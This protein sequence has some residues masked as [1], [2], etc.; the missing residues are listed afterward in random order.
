MH[1]ALLYGGRSSEHDVSIDSARNI[2]AVL[3]R[4]GYDVL[5]IGITLEGNFYLQPRRPIQRTI[6]QTDEVSVLPG[7]G[8]GCQGTLLPIDAAFPVTHGTGGEDGNLQGLCYLANI[9]LCGCDT[10]SSALGMH[11]AITQAL[12]AQAGIPVVPTVTLGKTDLDWLREAE[13]VPRPSFLGDRF[14]CSTCT[15]R[16]DIAFPVLAEQ[17]GPALLAKPEASGS[18]VGVTALPHAD[19]LSLHGAIE[20]AARYGERV[21]VQPLLDPVEEI[22]CA[23]L[24]TGDGQVVVSEPGL[25]IDPAHRDAGFLT[26]EH[27]Y[28]KTDTAHMEVPAPLDPSVRKQIQRYA[29]TAF[30][31]IKGNGYARIDFFRHD[32]T[33]LLNEINTLPGMTATSHYPAL[34]ADKGYTLEQ[35]VRTLVEEAVARGAQTRERILVPPGETP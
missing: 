4:L 14:F 30:E 5:P 18:S 11:K 20:L 21:L 29:S 1:I 12:L 22:E 9:P 8:F 3:G 27:K 2:Q 31:A 6:L 24:A 35:V 33:I 10:V 15:S 23:L 34:M 13:G 26:Y 28:G 19:A 7:K 16:I 17:L 25:V 32:G